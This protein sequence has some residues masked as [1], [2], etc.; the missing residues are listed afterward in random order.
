VGTGPYRFGEFRP[1]DLLRATINT[2]YHAPLRPHFDTLEIKG[3]GDAAS[4]AR[5]VL[6]TGEYDYGWTLLVDDDVLRRMERGDEAMIK[7]RI[8]QTLII[9]ATLG[10]RELQRHAVGKKLEVLKIGETAQP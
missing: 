9:R 5:A 10:G 2:E 6:Q 1:G 4:A 7:A 3:G 8:G